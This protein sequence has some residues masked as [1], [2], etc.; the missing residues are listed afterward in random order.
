MIPP[1]ITKSKIIFPISCYFYWRLSGP[2]AP[3]GFVDMAVYH[4]EKPDLLYV[5][6][7]V[8]EAIA[9]S[10]DRNLVSIFNLDKRQKAMVET[11]FLASGD[12][13]LTI[14]T[15]AEEEKSE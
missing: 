5:T 15:T 1:W 7:T 6:G 8:P 10:G 3:D 12:R 9:R 13:E 11:R 14:G 2:I 4:R